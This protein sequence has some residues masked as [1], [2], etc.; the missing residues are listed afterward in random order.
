QRLNHYESTLTRLMYDKISAKFATLNSLQNDAMKII[1]L[2]TIRSHNHDL[3]IAKHRFDALMQQKLQ[4]LQQSF[5]QL[6]TKL[7]TLSPLATL[8]RGY[9]VAT[10]QYHEVIVSSEQVN[11]GDKI[12]VKLGQ[13]WLGCKV[14]T[15]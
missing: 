5:I 8:Q 4:S 13:G 14:E 11:I 2:H 10:N 7:D 1:P 6:A 9:A 15:T 3:K 12:D